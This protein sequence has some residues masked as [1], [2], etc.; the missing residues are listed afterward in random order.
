MEKIKFT[1]EI[2]FESWFEKEREP[3]TIASWQ[4]FIEQYFIPDSSVIG[5]DDGDFQDMIN[6]NKISIKAFVGGRAALLE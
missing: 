4:S 6:M 3:K 5:T 1:V 2:E